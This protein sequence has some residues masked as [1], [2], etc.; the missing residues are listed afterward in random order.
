MD[1]MISFLCGLRFLM[2][3]VN[4]VLIQ[5]ES[6]PL[7]R[8]MCN[9]DGPGNLWLYFVSSQVSQLPAHSSIP[10]SQNHL[11][12]TKYSRDITTPPIQSG[13][14]RTRSITS[15]L[16]HPPS[17]PRHHPGEHQL[18]VNEL[19]EGRR[20]SRAVA[21]LIDYH[22]NKTGLHSI[23]C[24]VQFMRPNTFLT[25]ARASTLQARPTI[26]TNHE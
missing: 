19:G 14:H 23:E 25:K 13:R 21:N 1:F 4:K 9:Y 11:S 16:F 15:T 20:I 3:E 6:L 7:T 10:P 24:M 8:Q 26:E 22:W 5:L 17:P 2:F 12:K 18:L